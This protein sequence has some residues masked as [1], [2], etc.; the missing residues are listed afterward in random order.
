MNRRTLGA[1][2]GL[3][4]V[5]AIAC[6]LEL[7]GDGVAFGW[8]PA[9]GVRRFDQSN[10]YGHIDGGAELFLELGFRELLLQKY[11]CGD[12]EIDVEAY[13]M[14]SPAAAIGIYLMRQGKTEATIA[15]LPGWNG[16]D[17]YQLTA[18]RGDLFLQ[19]NAFDGREEDVPAMVALAQAVL[20]QLA[21][22][23]PEPSPWA[24]LPAAGQLPGRR[25]LFTGPYSLQA[26]FTFGEGDILSQHGEV[27]GVAA[28][29]D[30]A[31]TTPRTELAVRYQ[32]EAA[33]GEAYAFL[34]R[35]L[36]SALKVLEKGEAALVFADYQGKF[37]RIAREGAVLRAV[38]HLAARPT[39]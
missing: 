25:L 10:L 2:M 29:Y 1:V 12:R 23:E 35:N 15:G 39:L 24:L 26:I 22:T 17:R 9:G 19:V 11:R 36:D 37:G 32:G 3:L 18:R 28:E 7:P 33:A 16:G 38:L 30:G 8:R 6:A 27:L 13:Q 31:G 5:P 14:A 34:A 20:T 4:L 21:D